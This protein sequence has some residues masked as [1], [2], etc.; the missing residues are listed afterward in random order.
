MLQMHRSIMPHRRLLLFKWLMVFIPP[1]TVAVG[2]VLLEYWS[3]LLG[4]PVG[5]HA[6]NPLVT[7]LVILLV[8]FLALV[9]AYIFL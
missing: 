7:L 2:H 8:T 3:P 1:V 9:L 5:R 6:E 4:H